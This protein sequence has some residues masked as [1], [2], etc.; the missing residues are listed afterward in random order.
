M[1]R[2]GKSAPA[3][4]TWKKPVAGI[5]IG[6]FSLLLLLGLSS[7]RP[8]A[9]AA[10][11]A[12]PVG[13]GI[14]GA[15][16]ETAGVGGYA[17]ALFLIAVACALVIGRPRI[18]FAR[19]SSWLLFSLCAM[20]LLDLVVRT[21]LQGHPAGGAAGAMLGGAARSLLSVPGAAVLLSALGAAALVIATDLWA[22]HAARGAAKLG[23]AGGALAFK[24][25]ALAI[26]K[27]RTAS[28]GDEPIEADEDARIVLPPSSSRK[29]QAQALARAAAE[30]PPEDPR[31]PVP[32]NGK[33]QGAVV[34]SD[35]GGGED[36]LELHVSE[37]VQQKAAPPPQI[38]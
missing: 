21:R 29:A 18:S 17:L 14:A 31:E 19:A 38:V 6:G 23:V 24:G 16:L 8:R 1:G 35:S 20:G 10:N 30:E 9:A 25:A 34:K 5:L 2:K 15:L 22:L 7:Y 11:W 36:P 13:H 33:R 32:G 28:V 27:A 37:I 26:A 12:G 3:K 4:A